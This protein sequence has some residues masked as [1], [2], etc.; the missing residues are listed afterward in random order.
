MKN[1]SFNKPET[2]RNQSRHI[3]QLYTRH[4]VDAAGCLSHVTDQRAVVPVKKLLELELWLL[5]SGFK[6]ATKWPS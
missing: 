3:K 2:I 5:N 4:M 6:N 1:Q